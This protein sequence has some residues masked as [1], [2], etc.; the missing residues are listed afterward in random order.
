[1]KKNKLKIL[2]LALFF[3]LP[4]SPVLAKKDVEFTPNVSIPGSSQFQAGV[5]TTLGSSFSSLGSYI[6]D[7][8]NY[9][10]LIVGLVAAIVLMVAGIIWLTAA[11]NTSRISAAKSWITG[12]LTGL[13]LALSSYLILQTINPYLTE[14]RDINLKSISEETMGC[15][16][17]DNEKDKTGA[18][19]GEIGKQITKELS[20]SQCYIRAL[21]LNEPN[22][23][24]YEELKK[25][26]DEK[27]S[28]KNENNKTLNEYIKEHLIEKNKF[29]PN[30][31]SFAFTYCG[32]T[33]VSF[34]V[35]NQTKPENK[36]IAYCFKTYSS[37]DHKC[38]NNR[39]REHINWDNNNSERERSVELD[40]YWPNEEN[41]C[42]QDLMQ[43]ELS[44]ELQHNVKKTGSAGF[45]EALGGYK[46]YKEVVEY[47][48]IVYCNVNDSGYSR[49]ALGEPCGDPSDNALCVYSKGVNCEDIDGFKNQNIGTG[50]RRCG[51]ELKCCNQ[52]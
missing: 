16:K 43:R 36:K 49:G 8:Y 52:Q 37:I 12:S 2:I 15:C 26:Y 40:Y 14:F 4:F 6:K 17:L 31:K 10:I 9:L 41:G 38:L 44:T 35:V 47:N 20:V 27:Y 25:E 34:F 13:V 3:L 29:Y 23:K 30:Q 19:T 45:Y 51:E 39:L 22:V 50:G 18:L 48:S 33:G 1:M 46:N 32:S 5:S 24:S 42:T 28:K 7:I 11:G 21:E